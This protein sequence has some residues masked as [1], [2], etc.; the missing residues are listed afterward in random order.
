MRPQSAK[1]KGRRLQQE[2]AR[3]IKQVFNLPDSDVKSIP[4]GSQGC[5]IWLSEAAMKVFPFGVE[6]KNVE[7][8]NAAQAYVQAA[9]NAQ[10]GTWPLLVHSKNR[11]EVL[12]TLKFEDLLW[13]IKHGVNK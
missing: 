2:T 8:L 9:S 1:A 5:D 4:M 10:A 7:K 12:A 6:C 11:G 3:R 13:L